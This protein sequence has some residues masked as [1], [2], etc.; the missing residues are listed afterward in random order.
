MKQKNILISTCLLGNPVRYNGTGKRIQHPLITKWQSENRLIP[1][2]PELAGGLSTPRAAAEI[3]QYDGNDVINGHARVINN[4]GKD[5]TDPFLLGAQKALAIAIE[6]H[7]AFAILTERSPSC[8]SHFIYDG[9]FTGNT[10]K[11]MGVT[12]A[13]LEKNGIQVFNQ[14]QLEEI[15]G[16]L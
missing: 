13:L 4:E 10:V 16:L 14:H 8:G 6:K 2:C 15:D 5:V 12:S 11:G 1:V 7:C 9:S 3:W